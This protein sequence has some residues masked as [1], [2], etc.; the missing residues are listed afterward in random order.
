VNDFFKPDVSWALRRVYLA[1]IIE[2]N[3][4]QVIADLP[5]VFPLLRNMHR[6]AR[7][8]F[9]SSANKSRATYHNSGTSTIGSKHKRFNRSTGNSEFSR[10][11]RQAQISAVRPGSDDEIP[12]R[13]R[14][15]VV[16]PSPLADG[17]IAVQVN[18]DVHSEDGSNRV[19]GPAKHW[20]PE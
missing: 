2:R 16:N 10:Y 8:L 15:G 14:P 6:K 5:V 11:G 4:A 18:I 20:L 9:S 12:L 1:T 13:E 17:E 3:V 7:S 19:D